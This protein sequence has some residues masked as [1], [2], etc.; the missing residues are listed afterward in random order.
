MTHKA[1]LW[2]RNGIYYP[3]KKVQT[4]RIEKGWQNVVTRTT[5]PHVY[6]N[7]DLFCL[8]GFCL[9]GE[10]IVWLW[11]STIRYTDRQCDLSGAFFSIEPVLMVNRVNSPVLSLEL[12]L[13][14]QILT[15]NTCNRI[16]YQDLYLTCV[17]KWTETMWDNPN[18]SCEWTA[19]AYSIICR[20]C[21]HSLL[22]RVFLWC[23]FWN[24]NHTKGCQSSDDNVDLQIMMMKRNYRKMW[25]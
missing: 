22:E 14:L 16:T 11:P 19:R 20:L 23:W 15:T 24:V 5:K 21:C 1:L 8:L 9:Y 25:L 2:W 13:I 6:G 18:F 4:L 7:K 3:R 12:H 17:L 10:K